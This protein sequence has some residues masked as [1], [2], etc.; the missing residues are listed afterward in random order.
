M[1]KA[2]AGFY[3]LRSGDRTRACVARV[4][5]LLAAVEP[6]SDQDD[7]TVLN[8]VLV[9]P[10]PSPGAALRY[11]LLDNSTFLCGHTVKTHMRWPGHK[12]KESKGP[13]Q[14]SSREPVAVAH[15]NWTGSLAEKRRLLLRAGFWHLCK[16]V[17][18]AGLEQQLRDSRQW[19]DAEG[20]ASG[21]KPRRK[22]LRLK[23]N[24]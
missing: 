11:S 15:V 2:N 13:A 22:T 14:V 20:L 6:G 23:D 17:G 18:P 16:G 21:R 1:S 12:L 24:R 7:Q 8:R 3:Y 5:E 4:L 9:E 19:F 10:S